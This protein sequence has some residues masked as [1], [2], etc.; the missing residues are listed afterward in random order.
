M[1]IERLVRRCDKLT[2]K[3][4]VPVAE[5]LEWVQADLNQHAKPGDGLDHVRY[6]VGRAKRRV[7]QALGAV[8]ESEE[9]ESEEA[10]STENE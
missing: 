9:D 1:D 5:N 3:C 4:L 10:D 2:G 8:S 6:E 7:D